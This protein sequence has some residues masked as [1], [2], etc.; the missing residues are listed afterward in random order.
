MKRKEAENPGGKLNARGT[1][2]RAWKPNLNSS[3]AE[4]PL[5]FT[6]KAVAFVTHLKAVTLGFGGRSPER[7][8]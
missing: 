1:V 6:T 7:A 3:S 5:H 2:R 4:I 8:E